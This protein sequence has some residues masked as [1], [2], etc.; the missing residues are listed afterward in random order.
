MTQKI[1]FTNV[2]YQADSS[3]KV[4]YRTYDNLG[5]NKE[6][7]FRILGAIPP[8]GKYF[9]VGGAQF[10]H[11]FYQGL[12]EGKPLSF[13]KGSWS[14]FTYQ[15]LKL[16][17]TSQ[18]SLNG[19]VR[20]K[21][22]QQ[23][24]ELSPFGSLNLSLNQQFFKKKLVVTLSAN[25]LFYTNQNEFTL[26]QGSISAN[27][28][29]KSDSRRFGINMRYSFGIRKKDQGNNFLDFQNPDK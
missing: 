9:I 3:K 1:F 4:A 28:Y 2:V 5:S 7:Y 13:K 8:G 19:F 15:T 21:G 20:L 10:N 12:Y 24:Y 16:S 29:R 23:F 17:R 6:S 27:G 11:N 25:D 14:L 22:Q 18:L 26:K